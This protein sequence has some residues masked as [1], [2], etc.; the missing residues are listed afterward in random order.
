M[1]LSGPREALEATPEALVLGF[2]L[3]EVT[4]EFEVV[5]EYWAKCAGA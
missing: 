4:A 1:R 5:C 2:H 3:D